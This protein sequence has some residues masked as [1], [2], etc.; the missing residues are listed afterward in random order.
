M[1][2]QTIKIS[3]MV[4]NGCVATITNAI[5]GLPGIEKVEVSLKKANAFIVFDDAEVSLDEIKEAISDSGYTP[6]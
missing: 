3:G 5:K 1:I 4:C 6:E 2:E